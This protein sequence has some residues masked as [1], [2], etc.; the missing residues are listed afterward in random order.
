MKIKARIIVVDDNCDL[1]DS[2]REVLEEHDCFVEC[3]A[4]GKEAI[5]LARNN[6]YDIAFIDLK[7]PDISGSEVV[8]KIAEISPST[9]FIYMTGHASIDS[10]VEAVKQGRVVS[11]ETKPLDLHRL[12]PLINQV[13]ERKKM[14]EVL[15]QSEKLK[16]IGNMTAGISHEFN[17][18]LNII[19]G[20]VQLLQMDYKDHKELMDRLCTIK[21]SV[22]DG[23]EIVDRMF[24]FTHV[25]KDIAGF[26]CS[27]INELLKQAIEFTMPRWK[28]MAQAKGINYH[29]DTEGMK[30]ISSILCNP[31]KIREVFINIINNALDAMPDGGCLSFRTWSKDDTV[32][33]SITDTGSGMTEDVKKSIFDPFF[34]TRRPERTGL[35]MST[36]FSIIVR[37]SGKIEVE[38]EVSKGTTL[39][40]SFPI[41]LETVQRTVSTELTREKEVKGLHILVVDDEENI[42]E[43]L[44]EFFSKCG[45]KVKAVNNGTEAIELAKR[46]VFDLVLCDLVMPDV[47]GYDVIKVLNKLERRPKIGIMTGW[48]EKLKPIDDE[49]FKVNFIVKKPFNFSELIKA[50]NDVIGVG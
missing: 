2:I 3:A 8:E 13:V 42:C 26:V 40:L 19:S 41:T 10:A 37:H 9:E 6:I 34:T 12:L 1:S 18:I 7:L 32:F 48:G 47:Y 22:D 20:N 17:N 28:S 44:I 25:K 24:E 35:G 31:I 46:E 30:N 49:D 11:Y 21:E 15:R 5:E 36:S 39:T 45:H 38:S 33:A 14:E 29:M 50:I 43:V 16:S 27:D 23:A 4:N